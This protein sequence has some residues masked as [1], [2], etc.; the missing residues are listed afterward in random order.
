MLFIGDSTNR[1]MMH[2][3]MEQINDTL[4]EWDKTHDIKVYLNLNEQRTS[5]SFTYYPQ[6]WLPTSQRPMFDTALYQLLKQ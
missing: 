5:V 4:T 2:Y 1:G 3:L 6:F